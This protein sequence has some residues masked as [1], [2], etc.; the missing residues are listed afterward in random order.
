[1]RA[2][3]FCGSSARANSRH[4]RPAS[5]AGCQRIV[6]SLY[7]SCRRYGD[8]NFCSL[9]VG[10]REIRTKAKAYAAFSAGLGVLRRGYRPGRGK[11]QSASRSI[12]L[13]F[14]PIAL[15]RDGGTGRRS[16]L[17][18]RRALRPWGFDSPSRHHSKNRE[19]AAFGPSSPRAIHFYSRRSGLF[20]VGIKDVKAI[21][22]KQS[23]LSAKYG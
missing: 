15:S 17:K 11:L 8:C 23:C 21:I 20:V 5:S 22:L 3:L 4:R 6:I 16:G 18:I 19:Y 7:N 10:F 9:L 2:C 12:S 14:C 13:G 1:V